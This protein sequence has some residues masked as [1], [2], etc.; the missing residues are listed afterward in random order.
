MVGARPDEV[1]LASLAGA[2]YPTVRPREIE[3]STVDQAARFSPALRQA[4]WH[5]S[6]ADACLSRVMHARHAALLLLRARGPIS[7]ACSSASIAAHRIEPLGVRL[8]ASGGARASSS[9][10]DGARQ[11]SLKLFTGQHWS[12]LRSLATAYKQLSKFR[13]SALVVSTAG[14]GYIA[15]TPLLGSLG[16]AVTVAVLILIISTAAVS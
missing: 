16:T 10:A 13:L 15:G 12:E 2:S 6:D 3:T 8:A 14:A 5:L 11:V 4:G 1:C 9:I 7:E